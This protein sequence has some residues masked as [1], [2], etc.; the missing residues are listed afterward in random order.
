M[1][2]RQIIECLERTHP[3]LEPAQRTCDGVKYGDTDRECTGVV[4]TCC[5]MASVIRQAAQLGANLII[6]HEPTFY[7][8]WDTV[9][10]LGGNAVYEAKKALLDATGMVIYRDHDHMHSEKP[11]GIFSAVVKE[12]GWADYAEEKDNLGLGMLVLPETTVLEIAR[13]FRD[14]VGIRGLRIIGD[15][16]IRVSRVQFSAHFLGGMSDLDELN[17]LDRSECELFIGGEMVDWTIGEYISDSN[18][19]GIKKA[20][21]NPGHFNWEELGM[22][23]MLS[24]LPALLPEAVPFHFIQSGDIYRWFGGSEGC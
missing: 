9:D 5:P 12:L 21:L 13:H 4:V 8:H 16:M 20:V 14:T 24:W 11:D 6:A 23:H 10:K 3:V 7:S 19:L 18:A 15:P 1:K 22:K 17:Q 2:I